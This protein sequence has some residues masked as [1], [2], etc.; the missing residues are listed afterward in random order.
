VLALV[1]TTSDDDGDADTHR[2]EVVRRSR[3]HNKHDSDKD[4]DDS[5]A[6]WRNAVRVAAGWFR[7]RS[8]LLEGEPS[9]D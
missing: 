5:A 6:T 8:L 2:D 4:D 7:H 9:D 1:S 3:A